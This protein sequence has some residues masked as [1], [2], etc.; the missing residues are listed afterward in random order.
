MRCQPSRI[1]RVARRL[2]SKEPH[3]RAPGFAIDLI[4]RADPIGP[5]SVQPHP[6]RK[7]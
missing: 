7:W 5:P 1:R 2:P 3:F 4:W 6:V